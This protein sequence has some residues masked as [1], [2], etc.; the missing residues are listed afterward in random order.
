MCVCVSVCLCVC[1]CLC[2]GQHGYAQLHHLHVHPQ[3]KNKAQNLY[4]RLGCIYVLICG[5]RHTKIYLHSN[6]RFR[7]NLTATLAAHVD[8]ISDQHLLSG[9]MKTVILFPL[10]S[11][12]PRPAVVCNPSIADL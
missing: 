12:K 9:Q 1:V 7:G 4:I 11:Q 5:H 10:S 2:G 3:L 8:L 6:K